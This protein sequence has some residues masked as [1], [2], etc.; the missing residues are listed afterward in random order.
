MVHYLSRFQA[1]KILDSA[2]AG[3]ASVTVSL[4]LGMTTSTVSFQGGCAALPDGQR[5]SLDVI[6]AIAAEPVCFRLEGGEASKIQF[7]QEE[8]RRFYRLIPTGADTPPTAELSG[9]RMHRMKGTDPLRD[10]QSKID[11]VRPLGPRVL[12]TCCGLGY[13]AVCASGGGASEVY[14]VE[15][16]PGMERLCGYNPWSCGLSDPRIRRISA[17]V[18]DE[19]HEF[20]GGFFDTVIHDPPTMS[21]AGELYSLEFYR[22]LHRVLREG[23]RI[24]HYVGAPGSRFRG[25]KPSSGV[26][27]RMRAAGFALVDDRPDI[28]GV[29]AVK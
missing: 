28:L 1:E 17:D 11:A 15:K 18:L 7:F 14:T 23:G 9:F 22:Q 5:I 3:R 20:D 27:R 6:E 29:S 4:D 21:L 16:D 10:A 25:R 8:T 24:F 12:D 13:T 19:V 2:H 26:I